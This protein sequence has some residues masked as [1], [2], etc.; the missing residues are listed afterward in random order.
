M[1]HTPAS[2]AGVGSVA[3][4]SKEYPIVVRKDCF[5]GDP[6]VKASFFGVS[7]S[8]EAI[9][10]LEAGALSSEAMAIAMGWP[11]QVATHE[12]KWGSGHLLYCCCCT[13]C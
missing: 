2:C 9:A 10:S 5:A 11:S 4:R 7:N 12:A 1:C 6:T 13:G 8:S 3:V